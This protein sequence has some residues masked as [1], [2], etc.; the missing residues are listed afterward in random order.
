M[1][2]EERREKIEAKKGLGVGVSWERR[3]K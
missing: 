3:R 2:D 1:A